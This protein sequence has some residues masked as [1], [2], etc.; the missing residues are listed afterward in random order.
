MELKSIAAI[1]LISIAIVVLFFSFKAVSK[2]TMGPASVFAS[3]SNIFSPLRY[4]LENIAKITSKTD[5]EIYKIET[6]KI[7][8]AVYLTSWSA[9]YSSRVDYVINLAKTAGVNAVVIDIKDY[10]GYVAYDSKLPEV[11]SY[12][13]KSLK[14]PDVGSLIKKLHKEG[15]YTVA[16]IVVF[17]DPALAAARNDWAIQGKN[18]VSFFSL[19]AAAL[20]LWFDNLKLS[21][22]DPSSEDVWNY[23]IAIAKEASDLGFD[24][25]NFDYVRFPSDGDLKNMS[26]PFWDGKTSKHLII[27]KFFEKIRESLPNKKISIDLFGLTTINYDDLGV[28]QIIE[29]AFENFDYI[30]PMVYPSHYASGFLGYENPAQYPYEVVKYSM[31]SA[32]RR[33]VQYKEGIKES[34]ND[35][36]EAN[37]R[38]ISAKLRPWLQDFN[39]GAVY[40]QDMV[41]AEINASFQALGQDYSGFMLWNASNIYHD[42][43]IKSEN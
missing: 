21:W 36:G 19:W 2:V 3:I 16:R 10:S 24:E 31:E 35:G 41:K 15:I 5:E 37:N 42:L 22:V 23:N 29:D 40:D 33:L 18:N 17:Q 28:G 43:A 30:C 25:I 20:S 14:I 34:N 7:V 9:G 26:F 1:I 13:T 12:N 8:K 27:K 6:P 11:I 38:G 39:M 32:N 4:F